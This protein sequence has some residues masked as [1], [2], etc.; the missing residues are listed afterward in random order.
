MYSPKIY[1]EF[2][3]ELYREAKGRGVTMT[4]LVNE[5]IKQALDRKEIPH[6]ERFQ[7]GSVGNTDC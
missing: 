5:I 3:P 7:V 2:I 6:D 4:K 1:E